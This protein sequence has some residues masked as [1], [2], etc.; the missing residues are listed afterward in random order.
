MS[1]SL[2]IFLLTPSQLLTHLLF[3][4]LLL[5]NDFLTCYH[6]LSLLLCLSPAVS[7]SLSLSQVWCFACGGY[8]FGYRWHEYRAL[9]TDGGTTAPVKLLR[10]HQTRDPA[11]STHRTCTRYRSAFN[12][13]MCAWN[14]D[15]IHSYITII[16]RR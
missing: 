4:T 5:I 16:T 14:D 12:T 3:L 6:I 11:L 9:F 7:L 8:S 2:Q 10:A 1:S 15:L 13:H